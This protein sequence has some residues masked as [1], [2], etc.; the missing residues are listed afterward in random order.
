MITET[1]QAIVDSLHSG[2]LTIFKLNQIRSSQRRYNNLEK[3]LDYSIAYEVY[4]YEVKNGKQERDLRC[5]D[6]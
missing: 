4:K 3:S 2:E 1:Q 6:K 5:W